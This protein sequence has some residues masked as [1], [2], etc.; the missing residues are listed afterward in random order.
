MSATG[1]FDDFCHYYDTHT[2]TDQELGVCQVG[3]TNWTA[4]RN[5]VVVHIKHMIH[6]FLL[7]DSIAY[8]HAYSVHSKAGR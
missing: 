3:G 5:C 8:D 2:H 4:Y 6:Y 1:Q 7:L